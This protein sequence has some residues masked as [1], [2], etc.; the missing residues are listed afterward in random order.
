MTL[1]FIFY[2]LLATLFSCILSAWCY[3]LGGL[4]K[5]DGLKKFPKIP[6]W[7]IASWVRDI[8][9]STIA[10]AWM[11]LFY[12][13]VPW[14]VYLI[15]YIAMWGALSTYWD[16]VFGYD[17]YFAHGFMIAFAFILFAIITK[18]WLG[19]GVRTLTL[20]LTMGIWCLFFSND[21]VEEFGRGGFIA[22]TLPLM[23]N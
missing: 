15:S 16:R 22:A 11:I 5:E 20:A 1:F 14:Y 8:G 6:S 12:Q 21:D 18:N 3:R 17:N 19:L 7:L 10:V 2:I 13:R 9:C 4:S 23:L